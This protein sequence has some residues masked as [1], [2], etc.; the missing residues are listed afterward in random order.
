M[1]AAGKRPRIAQV[2]GGFTSN[3]AD[4]QGV[5]HGFKLRESLRVEDGGVQQVVLVLRR[6]EVS[7]EPEDFCDGATHPAGKSEALVGGAEAGR[8]HPLRVDVHR[9]LQRTGRKEGIVSQQAV[10]VVG[11]QLAPQLGVG[12]KEVAQQVDRHVR[13]RVQMERFSNVVSR[14]LVGINGQ[15]QAHRSRPS[16]TA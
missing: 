6:A 15:A 10:E 4:P 12:D 11:L 13:P 2:E 8:I 7:V 14:R 5:V 9:A 1:H 16:T 3:G